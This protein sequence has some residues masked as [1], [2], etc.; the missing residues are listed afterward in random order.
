MKILGL[1]E[2]GRGAVVSDIVMSCA[3]VDDNQIPFLRT[4]GVKDS[5]AFK[6]GKNA[7]LKRK[8]ICELL[9]E[10]LPYK[11]CF[12]SAKVIDQYVESSSK[13]LDILEV[14]MADELIKWAISIA[15]LKPDLIVLDSNK[16][17][18]KLATKIEKEFPRV[19]CQALDKADSKVM[20]VSAASIIAKSTRDELV[21]K[22]M[23]ERYFLKG[24]GY[25]N[26]H[27]E[28][29]I[30]SWYDIR[31]LDYDF[32]DMKPPI[33]HIRESWEWWKKLKKQLDKENENV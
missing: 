26:K 29:W 33:Q 1:D 18:R 27:S 21:E 13:S 23:G 30:R 17:F 3:L 14:E 4:I 8:E 10:I 16:M 6:T 28:E 24:A 11:T 31:F 9:K 7:R 5:K 15:G 20:A 32:V 25:P 12:K 19:K 22:V 2:A